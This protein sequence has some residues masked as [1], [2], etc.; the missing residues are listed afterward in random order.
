M[1]EFRVPQQVHLDPQNYTM[2]PWLEQVG[3]ASP[4]E[5]IVNN[6]N[7]ESLTNPVYRMP[8]P[9]GPGREFLP[10]IRRIP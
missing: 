2:H 9:D 3:K 6:L 5:G 10:A 1:S 4:L 8:E 7:F